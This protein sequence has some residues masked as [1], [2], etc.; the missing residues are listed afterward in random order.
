MDVSEESYQYL[1]D[2][3]ADKAVGEE[4]EEIAYLKQAGY[5]SDHH[6][7]KIEHPY[8]K[9]LQ[10]MLTRDCQ[11]IT[12]QV[13]QNC[14]FRC[15]YCVYSNDNQ[16]SQR[17][18]S[19][20]I[21][22]EETAF[23]A[24]DFLAEHSVD[25]PRVDIGF[26]GGEPLLNFSLVEKCIAYANRRLKGKLHTF[27]MTTNASLLNDYIVDVLAKNQVY[28]TI[29]FDGPERIQNANR[30]LPGYKG[31]TYDLVRNNIRRMRERYPE[32]AAT[33]S[34]NMVIDPSF[35][36]DYMK[37]LE[38][39]DV[40]SAFRLQLSSLD[41]T[42]TPENM[43]QNQNYREKYQYQHML[44]YLNALHRVED[45]KIPRMLLAEKTFLAELKTKYI[46]HEMLQESNTP[47]GPCIPGQMRL[48]FDVN[49]N[50][51]PCERVSENAACFVIG[52]LKDGYDFPQAYSILN[53]AQISK[54]ECKKCWAFF[55]CILCAKFAEKNGK[56]DPQIRL[57]GCKSS[58][59]TM[60]HELVDLLL[61]HEAVNYCEA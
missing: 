49:G 45:S 12:L 11:K 61:L 60:Y 25:A 28:L 7:E 40:F 5:L 37:S 14:N 20:K 35:D 4:P 48:F 38:E 43:L 59:D 50:M 32:Y 17:H 10:E 54:N 44:V 21:M 18:H 53:V 42:Y 24:I 56:L 39:D 29:S 41:E 57:L 51:Y 3:L 55:H 58:R 36:F 26:Y 9:Y 34:I 27:S 15:R 33:V 23:K 13:T 22:S 8:S 30:I 19:A 2:L 1:Q 47:G 52:N 31:G 46:V 6:V 16:N